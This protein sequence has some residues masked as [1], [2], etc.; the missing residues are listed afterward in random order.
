LVNASIRVWRVVKSTDLIVR[1]PNCYSTNGLTYQCYN[2]NNYSVG[3]FP[4]WIYLNSYLTTYT[5]K[6]PFLIKTLIFA[7]RKHSSSGKASSK[8]T[9]KPLALKSKT[10]AAKKSNLKMKMTTSP[11]K[12]SQKNNIFRA[13]LK[14]IG[15]AKTLRKNKTTGAVKGK[16]QAKVQAKAK[17][18]KKDNKNKKKK[19]A[20]VPSIQSTKAKAKNPPATNSTNV[21]VPKQLKQATPQPKKITK[22]TSSTLYIPTIKS[23]KTYTPVQTYTKFIYYTQPLGYEIFYDDGM[24][25]YQVCSYSNGIS[26]CESALTL[27]STFTIDPHYSYYGVRFDQC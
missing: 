2:Q 13:K 11:I 5:V 23:V 21:V 10:S 27:P 18:N 14:P 8:K 6:N 20:K 26:S 1:S 24:L 22:P 15:M 3:T 16:S 25:S 9:L 19:I 4:L 12:R 7:A 17:I